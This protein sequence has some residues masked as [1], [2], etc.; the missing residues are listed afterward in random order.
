MSDDF[1]LPPPLLYGFSMTRLIFVAVSSVP[2]WKLVRT[3][4]EGRGEARKDMGH[5]R[6]SRVINH[7]TS[8]GC[9]WE[10][11]GLVTCTS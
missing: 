3:I 10:P 8:G 6:A 7:R 4:L 11:V 9:G 5:A 2:A 1:P